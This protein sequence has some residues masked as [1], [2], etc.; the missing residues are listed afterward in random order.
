MDSPLQYFAFFA[1]KIFIS[2]RLGIGRQSVGYHLNIVYRLKLFGQA[3]EG[4]VKLISSFVRSVFAELMRIGG[5]H[6]E[7]TGLRGKS[8]PEAC[9]C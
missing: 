6:A 5:H 9:W 1:A 7:I 8:I 2:D 4:V 3:I